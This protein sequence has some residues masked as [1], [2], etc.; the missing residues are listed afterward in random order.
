[1]SAAE[2]VLDK[3]LA[4]ERAGGN[5]DLARELFS[6]LLRELP[7]YRRRIQN[8]YE[9]QQYEQLREQIHKLNGAATYCGVP[10]LKT[11]VDDFESQLKR[12]ET[13]GFADSM[14]K[15]LDAIDQVVAEAASF[16]F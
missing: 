10:L 16:T 12:G 15:S 4:L 14:T 2:R 8:L 3:D 6:M 5:A 11:V 13:E 7:E 1:M 9:A